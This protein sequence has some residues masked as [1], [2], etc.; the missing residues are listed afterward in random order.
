MYSM[1]TIVLRALKVLGFVFLKQEKKFSL[2]G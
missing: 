1:Q 2:D